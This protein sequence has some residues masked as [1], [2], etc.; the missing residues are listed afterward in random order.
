MRIKKLVDAALSARAVED[1]AKRALERQQLQMLVEK[2]ARR[3]ARLTAI[4]RDA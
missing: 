4:E 1:D 3:D 2:D